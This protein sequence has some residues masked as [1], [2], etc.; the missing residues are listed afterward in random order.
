ME[1]PLARTILKPLEVDG[2]ITLPAGSIWTGILDSLLRLW[3]H[4][5]WLANTPMPAPSTLATWVE[6]AGVLG[7]EWRDGIAAYEKSP[8]HTQEVQPEL[9]PQPPPEPVQEQVEER[10]DC[11]Y[12]DRHFASYTAYRTH[13]RMAHRSE[14]FL[15]S[16]VAFGSCMACRGNFGVRS[17]LLLHYRRNLQCALH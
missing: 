13:S 2:Q 15:G 3:S 5:S 8:A 14:G 12:C 1:S 6:I 17:N 11:A 7:Q 16:R 4:V 9:D 10:F